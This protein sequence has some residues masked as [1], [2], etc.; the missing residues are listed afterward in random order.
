MA[1]VQINEDETSWIRTF[2]LKE[3]RGGAGEGGGLSV[4]PNSPR[5]GGVAGT[6]IKNISCCV[7]DAKHSIE[8]TRPYPKENIIGPDRALL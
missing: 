7:F 8:R 6:M 1:S 2:C 5:G 3:G 4:Q